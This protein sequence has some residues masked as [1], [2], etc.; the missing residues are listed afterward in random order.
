MPQHALLEVHDLSVTFGVHKVVESVSFDLHRGDILAV[1]GPNGSGKTTLLKAILGLVEYE[2][3]VHWHEKVRIGYVPQKLEFDRTFPITVREAFLLRVKNGFWFGRNK[4]NKQIRAALKQV[5]AENLIDERL[6]ELSG[7]QLQRVLIAYS[8]IGKP[9]VLF[10]DE[11][12][13]GIDIG[14]EE[15]V[16]NLIHKLAHESELT[17]F[18]ISHDLDVVYR[19]ATEVLCINKKM[20]CNGLPREVL[21]G[22]V[23]EKLYGKLASTYEHHHK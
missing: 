13:T 11:P 21:T 4:N 8:L 2:G 23:L 18:L 1:I 12:S 16:Y 10:F 6:G 3:Q 22:D 20:V 17:V 15:T 5:G 19:H 7:G 9:D 14:G